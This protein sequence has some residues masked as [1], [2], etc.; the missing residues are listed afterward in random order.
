[1]RMCAHTQGYNTA[2]IHHVAEMVAVEVLGRK[3]KMFTLFSFPDRRRESHH[4]FCRGAL[5]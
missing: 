3:R 4:W 5:P 2:K 1:M